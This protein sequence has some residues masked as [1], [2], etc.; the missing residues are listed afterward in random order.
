M[1]KKKIIT[2][3][4]YGLIGIVVFNIFVATSLHVATNKKI[5]E[6]SNEN[7]EGL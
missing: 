5:K 7:K 1:N 4:E 3:I 2:F 6:F